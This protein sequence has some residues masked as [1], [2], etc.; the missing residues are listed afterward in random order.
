M[1]QTTKG[2]G[3]ET[4]IHFPIKINIIAKPL[5]DSSTGGREKTE[6]TSYL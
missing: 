2:V 3:V 5:A 4:G 6:D 1:K